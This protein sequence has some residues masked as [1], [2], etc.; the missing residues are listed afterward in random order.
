[1][2]TR[3]VTAFKSVGEVPI[4]NFVTFSPSGQIA[5]TD[6]GSPLT[7]AKPNGT[8]VT[9]I[10]SGN[11][12]VVF[13]GF[14]PTGA[15]AVFV[16]QTPSSSGG[17][18]LVYQGGRYLDVSKGVYDSTTPSFSS[19]GTSVAYA[20]YRGELGIQPIYGVTTYNLKTH[21]AR[22]LT[23]ERRMSDWA[24]VWSPDDRYLAFVR[25]QPQEAM[26]MGTGQV[27]VIQSDGAGAR[28]LDG[29]ASEVAWVQ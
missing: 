21:T 4:T 8:G 28:P 10:P 5:F 22:R 7:L 27:W 23:S 20:G 29:V 3:K 9:H 1:L 14:D 25:S 19:S 2:R 6:L 11:N 13:N 24:P 16:G 17:D 15:R 12:E 18:V 26:Y